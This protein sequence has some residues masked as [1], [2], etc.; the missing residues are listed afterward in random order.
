MNATKVMAVIGAVWVSAGTA[1]AGSRERFVNQIEANDRSYGQIIER[2]E[3]VFTQQRQ[4]DD[5]FFALTNSGNRD[6]AILLD[7][8]QGLSETIETL[9][10][11][12][13]LFLPEPAEEVVPMPDFRIFARQAVTRS[14]PNLMDTIYVCQER[15]NSHRDF[16]GVAGEL[17]LGVV[18]SASVNTAPRDCR[19]ADGGVCRTRKR[20][21]RL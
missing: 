6:Q 19:G 12:F 8:V 20:G 16:A 7:A 14:N 18:G 17:N 1:S 15:Q 2:L 10:Q 13:L 3:V 5:T 9:K 11:I 4:N 21:N